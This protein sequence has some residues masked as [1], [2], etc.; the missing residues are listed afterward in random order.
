MPVAV[1]RIYFVEPDEERIV[2]VHVPMMFGTALAPVDVG[3]HGEV[4]EKEEE[5]PAAQPATV[6]TSRTA[7]T[8]ATTL[9]IFSM[10]RD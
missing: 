2:P 10:S 9:S 6:S 7:A 8:P 5:S 3:L 4:E 1:T